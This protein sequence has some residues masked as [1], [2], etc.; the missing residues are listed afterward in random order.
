MKKRLLF[1]LAIALTTIGA[2]AISYKVDPSK[3]ITKSTAELDKV[4]C[5]PTDAASINVWTLNGGG[6][7]WDLK[8][9]PLAE[10]GSK[11]EYSYVRFE[12]P[13][14]DYSGCGIDGDI[15]LM[16]F[17]N[18]AGNVF[19]AWGGQAGALNMQ[20]GDQNTMFALGYTNKLFGQDAEY[21]A[22]WRVTQEG[23]GYILENVG[24]LAAG[25]KAYATPA[26]ASPLADKAYVK[27]YSEL[28]IDE[29]V[30]EPEPLIEDGKY[31]IQNVES[32]KFLSNGAA[33][34][35]RAVLYG[36]GIEYGVTF[37]SNANKYTLT[38]GIIS[39]NNALRP[40][41]GFNDQSGAWELQEAE[42]GFYMYNGSQYF[43]NS[44]NGIPQFKATPDASCVW[45]FV[46]ANE[47]KALLAD[48][49]VANPVDAT[50][51]IQ[52]A[53]FHNG[54]VANT[55]WSVQK[56]GGNASSG[57]T[58]L[59]NTNSEQWQAGIFTSSQAITGL[60]NGLYKVSC[61]GFTRFSDANAASAD[62]YENGDVLPAYLFANDKQVALKSV[63]EGALGA[64]GCTNVTST[65]GKVYNIPNSQGD[66][67]LRFSEGAYKNELEVTVT[68]GTLSLGI[69]SDGGFNWVVWDEF[70]LTYYGEPNDEAL[71]AAAKQD[72]EA[73]LAKAKGIDQ[74][75]PMRAKGLTALK[76]SITN[77]GD[78]T[79]TTVAEYETA[80]EDLNINADAAL[81]SIQFYADIKPYMDI[82]DQLDDA[83]KA[84][85]DEDEAGGYGAYVAKY[86]NNKIDETAYN[87]LQ[88]FND[89]IRPLIVEAIFAQTTPGSDFTYAIV[90]PNFDGNI[91]GWTD[92]YTSG[93]HNYQT[94]QYSNGDVTINQF[95][96]VWSGQWSSVPEPWYLPDGKFS[97]IISNLPAGK[98]TLEADM[99]ATQ[100]EGTDRE[101]FNNYPFGPKE[102]RKGIFLFAKSAGIDEAKSSDIQTDD[103]KP[104][105]FKFNFNAA[106]GGTEI[107][108][109]TENSNCVWV[110]IDN[111][112]LIYQGEITINIYHEDLK[113]AVDNA[114]ADRTSEMANKDCI[115]AYQNAYA[116]AKKLYN[117]ETKA[118]NV[119]EEAKTALADAT[120]ALDESVAIYK[121]IAKVNQK[122]ADENDANITAAYKDLLKA[123]NEKT[124]TIY[125]PYKEF[126]MTIEEIPA[127]AVPTAPEGYA[128]EPI[129]KNT[130]L[131]GES[132]D[133]YVV[134]GDA[135][136]EMKVVEFKNGKA[137]KVVGGAKVAQ[138]WDTQFF[139]VF[140][141]P[142]PVGETVNV[143]F[144]YK[145]DVAALGTTQSHKQPGS[146]TPNASIGDVNF[147][148][149]WKTFT[150]NF[151][152]GNADVQSVAFN[153]NEMAEANNY[154]FAN[155]TA[156]KLVRTEVID[157]DFIPAADE[158]PAA[159]A[160][161]VWVDVAANDLN[162][163]YV[164]G[165]TIKETKNAND[166][167][168][169]EIVSNAKAEGGNPWD[170]QFFIKADEPI[171][172]GIKYYLSFSYKAADNAKV[173]LQSQATPGS[174]LGG[175]TPGDIT[176]KSGEWQTCTVV[177]TSANDAFQSIA[178]NLNEK[179]EST[180]YYI[181]NIVFKAEMPV[182]TVAMNITDAGYATFCAPFDV[183]IPEG[184]EAYTIEG[185]NKE[186]GVLEM[187][188]QESIEANVPVVLAG[189]KFSEPKT[190]TGIAKK[191]GTQYG[192]LTGVY[193]KTEVPV[194]N[195]I[196]QK[197]GEKAAAFYK[198]AVSGIYARAN[199]AYLTIPEDSEVKD[200][201]FFSEEDAATAIETINA[202][203]SGKAEIYDM[204]GRKLEKL[205]KGVN[206]VNGKKVM[207]K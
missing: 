170:S 138:P 197:K 129:T 145:A 179:A 184:V 73:A 141:E 31:F 155:V 33:W 52:A 178:F 57:S 30:P 11:S 195:Y 201:Y 14:G 62:S 128:Y 89:D 186:N 6:N 86:K 202:L 147:G 161:M 90:N 102:D 74:T 101:G 29:T 95:F 25:G 100:R 70:R 2:K 112:K 79:Y 193:E 50:V 97:Q 85:A 150:G 17:V 172:N 63:F 119:Y 71:L 20:P 7:S 190:F 46:T 122:V 9:L 38:S 108:I 105:H 47:R 42:G 183:E 37:N 191:A 113:K 22:L 148:T 75:K 93:N 157:P 35:T 103:Y 164:Q 169:F 196:L 4:V 204:N 41:D 54:D 18:S 175:F 163:T 27:L 168:V 49:T 67:A 166:V 10:W 185:I 123:Y 15:Y 36:R 158:L 82:Y 167:K 83:G 26:S 116:E 96:E 142:L 32:G 91:N 8:N 64:S 120:K 118:N 115:D 28:A 133:S 45:K 21:H 12:K 106:D 109:K 176:C 162:S 171:A 81:K 124:A 40:S 139:I 88:E 76:K 130:D 177:A 154:Y 132:M 137:I 56:V 121:N 53:D 144:A 206:I 135:N 59:N 207:V 131:T 55:A 140:D 173:S 58:L 136:P 104:E 192:L 48:A 51:Y 111:V 180:T 198:V 125:E 143:S 127:V 134:K 34:G 159:S 189:K 165:A 98:Y 78:K 203:A 182:A 1:L 24:R 200:A 16:I 80:T 3:E 43:C 156:Y 19:P 87:S 39:A 84:K 23:N 151:E 94:S 65:S 110:A 99:I 66:A 68:D 77:Y 149:E 61:L 60:P 174:Y 146:W 126:L 199:S 205:Q 69:K 117:D 194:G 5:I 160:G 72:Y 44:D 152:I 13:T 181:A 107:G 153:L 92:A 114:N 187:I 188:Q